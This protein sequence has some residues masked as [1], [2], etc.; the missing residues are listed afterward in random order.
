MHRQQKDNSDLNN[1]CIYFLKKE[2][3]NEINGTLHFHGTHL[4]LGTALLE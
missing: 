2:I 4:Q 1:I 3:T